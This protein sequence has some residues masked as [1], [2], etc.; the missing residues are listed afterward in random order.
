MASDVII[1]P[2]IPAQMVNV[3]QSLKLTLCQYIRQWAP[4]S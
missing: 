4:A 3:S 1:F 2:D